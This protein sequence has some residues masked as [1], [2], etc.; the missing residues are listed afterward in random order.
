[1]GWKDYTMVKTLA[2][3]PCVPDFESPSFVLMSD[4]P[5]GRVRGSQGKL[6]S[7]IET[8]SS[9]FNERC[10]LTE[11]GEKAVQGDS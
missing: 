6:T 9:G 1:M 2:A 8:L 10:C 5:E 11:K 4:G 3:K 7:K